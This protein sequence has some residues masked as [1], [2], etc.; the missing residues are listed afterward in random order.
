MSKKISIE[1]LIFDYN[2]KYGTRFSNPKRFLST[3]YKENGGTNKAADKLIISSQSFSTLMK[4][5]GIKTESNITK[6]NK[7]LLKNYNKKYNTNYKDFKSL[8]ISLYHEHKELS[9]VARKFNA[10]LCT[11]RNRLKSYKVK[12]YTSNEKCNWTKTYNDKYNTNYT[13]LKVLLK[14]LIQTSVS[15]NNMSKELGTNSFSLKQ[16]LDAFNINYSRFIEKKEV[17]I[18]KQPYFIPEF[19]Y[20][21]ITSSPCLQCNMKILNKNNINCEN[22]KYLSQ[23]QESCIGI[24][25]AA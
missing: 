5:Y 24:R 1:K 12:L 15:L 22:C 3:L 13:E 23:Y 18:E 9:I 8:L 21:D 25:F 4:K 11:V 17:K 7:I 19:E 14:D 10:N 6:T 20:T 2:K 16:K